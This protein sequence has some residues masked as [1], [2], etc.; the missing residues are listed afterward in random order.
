MSNP[1]VILQQIRQT[2]I[3]MSSCERAS[4]LLFL[5]AAIAGAEV[6]P[7]VM[8]PRILRFALQLP[9]LSYDEQVNLATIVACSLKF[10]ELLLETK[11]EREKRALN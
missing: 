3:E 2:L 11:E 5:S 9:E 8:N 1:T 10:P 7:A 4:A 6:E